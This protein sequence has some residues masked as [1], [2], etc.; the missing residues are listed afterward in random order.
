MD[1]KRSKLNVKGTIVRIIK[2]GGHDFVCLSDMAKI[3]SDDPTFTIN[4]WMR[5]RMTIEYLG[6]WEEL[7]N[8]YFKPTEFGRF[9]SLGSSIGSRYL[10]IVT[11]LTLPFQVGYLLFL[12]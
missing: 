4:H 2:I 3:K 5:N 10:H 8:P 7:Y 1:R 9:R 11:V 6:L 12:I